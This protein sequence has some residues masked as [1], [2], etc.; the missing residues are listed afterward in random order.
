MAEGVGGENRN[1]APCEAKTNMQ[2]EDNSPQDR[3]WRTGDNRGRC[4][5]D[6]AQNNKI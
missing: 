1:G 2:T 6:G 5:E 3:E 4:I